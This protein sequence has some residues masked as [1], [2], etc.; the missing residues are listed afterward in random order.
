MERQAGLSKGAFAKMA[1]LAG[2]RPEHL[3]L[4]L[5][6]G[7]GLIE[8]RNNL[9][10]R[11]LACAYFPDVRQALQ[12]GEGLEVVAAREAE[13]RKV[14]GRKRIGRTKDGRPLFLSPWA[15]WNRARVILAANQP[16]LALTTLRGRS[17]KEVKGGVERRRIAQRIADLVEGKL[18]E[19]LYDRIERYRTEHQQGRGNAVLLDLIA[20]CEAQ[21]V[22]VRLVPVSVWMKRS[23][24]Y[25]R[26]HYGLRRSAAISFTQTLRDSI[27]E[28]R[29][30]GLLNYR[31]N[32]YRNKHPVPL[33]TDR[34]IVELLMRLE[35]KNIDF[36]EL[37]PADLSKASFR[38]LANRLPEQ[39]VQAVSQT[40][41]GRGRHAR[42]LRRLKREGY[43]Q[44][45]R[46]LHD[47]VRQVHEAGV[48]LREVTDT[49]LVRSKPEAISERYGHRKRR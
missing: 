32:A 47:V 6:L 4:G 10:A 43:R 45:A 5:S 8:T 12:R 22:N 13:V 38:E 14:V 2:L 21:G 15:A 9:A 33:R 17:R 42:L 28:R 19:S 31:S 3:R 37:G 35:R 46:T 25:I 26:R 20:R 27:G 40:M 39:G 49:D 44:S 34:E 11:L 1:D 41:L 16:L 18:G 36:D 30:Q 23:V 24:T 29:Y 48:D 7:A